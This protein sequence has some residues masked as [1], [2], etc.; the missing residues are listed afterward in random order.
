MA[1]AAYGSTSVLRKIG[2]NI[3]P[4]PMMGVVAQNVAAISFS[5]I[6]LLVKKDKKRA[7][8]KNRNAWIFFGLSGIM[9]LLGQLS[10]FYALMIGTVIIVSP[11]ST[12]SPLFVIVIAALF[13]RKL[14]KVTPKIVVGAVLIVAATAL[15][16]IFPT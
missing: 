1:G 7:T 2:L 8:W 9:S 13:L 16:S 12:I 3:N 15:L 5:G 14:E 6:L 10:L 11:L 4:D